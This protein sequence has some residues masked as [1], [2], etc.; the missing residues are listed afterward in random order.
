MK[1]GEELPLAMT[2]DEKRWW[3]EYAV[4]MMQCYA[5]AQRMVVESNIGYEKDFGLEFKMEAERV[6]ER[7]DTILSVDREVR[8][9]RI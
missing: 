3:A 4:A 8:R 9:G 1:I 7:L 2:M 5:S 6:I